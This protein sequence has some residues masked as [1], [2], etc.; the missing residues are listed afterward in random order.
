MNI[1]LEKFPDLNDVQIEQ[2][3]K[4]K[5]IYRIKA[6]NFLG[7]SDIAPLRKSDPGEKFPWKKLSR[8]NLGRWYKS[9][10]KDFSEINKNK[11]RNIFFSNLFKIGYRYFNK[12]KISK[13]DK[14]I[15]K[16]FKRR[17]FPQKID[18]KLDKKI[19][20]ISHFLANQ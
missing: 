4:L 1:I 7:H 15:I 3:S 9:S 11:Y 2:F 16:A 19:L 8:Y 10:K 13:K 18:E 12:K 17:Y 20:E 6:E 5:K 14:I